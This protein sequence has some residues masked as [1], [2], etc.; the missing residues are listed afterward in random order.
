MNGMDG[1]D[2]YRPPVSV[3]DPP[4]EPLERGRVRDPSSL[5]RA[6]IALS[7]A[8]AIADVADHLLS[9]RTGQEESL[10][11]SGWV[12]V[13]SLVVFLCWNYR[14]VKNGRITDAAVQT[15]G[16]GWAVG[17]YFVPIVNFWVPAKALMQTC[18]I[19]GAN[20][21]LVLVWWL[22]NLLLI[23]VILGYV[24]WMFQSGDEDWATTV[25]VVDHA[26]IVVSLILLMLEI[27]VVRTI[28]QAQRE[29]IV[30]RWATGGA[31]DENV[32]DGNREQ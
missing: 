25:G 18:R 1:H 27:Q 29:K 16:A 23:V 7:I 12:D 8:G 22:A 14:V 20:P 21:R 17:S 5:G 28:S 30:W 2:P 9:W 3:D 10:G 24:A 31:V 13:A 4:Q 26:L 11:W 6:V 15:V 19:F 32:G